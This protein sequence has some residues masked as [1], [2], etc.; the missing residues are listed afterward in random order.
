MST[1]Y[2]YFT[3]L[4]YIITTVQRVHVPLRFTNA[5]GLRL[6]MQDSFP[7]RVKSVHYVNP[8]KFMGRLLTFFKMFIPVKIRN[9]VSTY[10]SLYL[11][12][13]YNN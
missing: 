10:L 9:R 7:L 6:L 3:S 8:P 5:D 4:Q 11:G 12:H 1:G 13:K 2:G